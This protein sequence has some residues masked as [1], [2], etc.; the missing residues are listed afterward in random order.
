MARGGQPGYSAKLGWSKSPRFLC[1][2]LSGVW[3]LG[4]PV[5][6]THTQWGSLAPG[7]NSFLGTPVQSLL[8]PPLGRE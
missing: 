2:G 6:F 3:S 1:G 4:A 7:L 5:V 8:T